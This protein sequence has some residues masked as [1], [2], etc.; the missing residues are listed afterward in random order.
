MYIVEMNNP[1]PAW[2][3]E[4]LLHFFAFPWIIGRLFWKIR[5]HQAISNELIDA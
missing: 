2:E 4:A 1:K 5:I 3:N